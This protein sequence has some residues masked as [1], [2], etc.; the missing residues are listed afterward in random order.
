MI[1]IDIETTGE[2]PYLHSILS[3][4][5]VEFSNP[6]NQFYGECRV[7]QGAKITNIALRINGFKRKD[8]LD[9]NKKPQKKLLM[10]FL[11]W[12][13]RIEDNTLAGLNHYMDVYFL[14]YALKYYKLRNP[15]KY[16]LVDLHTIAFSHHMQR[17]LKPPTKTA[18]HMN[19]LSRYGNGSALSSPVIYKYCGMPEEGYPH[20]GLKGAKMEAE[21]LSRLIYGRN[22]IAE[23]KDFPIPRYLRKV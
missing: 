18:S 23:F 13:N 4:G 22:L 10:E 5:A 9:R 20:N 11:E 21:A 16:R 17:G 6:R 7:R 3:I 2:T 19:K 14:E 8:V 12:T 1:V 15:F